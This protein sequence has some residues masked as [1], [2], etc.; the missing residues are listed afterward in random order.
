MPKWVLQCR[1]ILGLKLRTVAGGA[2][3]FATIGNSVDVISLTTFLDDVDKS[4]GL[5]KTIL[6]T[7]N[8]S[9]NALI[10]AL[11]GSYSKDGVSG[12]VTQGPAWW[13]DDHK[14]GIEKMLEN[15]SVYGLL[16]N[17]IGMTTDSRS[18]LSFVRHDYFRRILC[19][20]LGDSFEKGEYICSFDEL[21]KLAENMC[22]YNVKNVEEE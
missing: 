13:W 9:D 2:G 17:F 7:L 12:L 16:W 1:F 6:F 4:I 11:S 8:P 21:L 22:Y 5:P 14:M 19:S 18:I 3:G 20:Y 15:N 10:S